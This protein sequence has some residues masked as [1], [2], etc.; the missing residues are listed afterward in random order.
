MWKLNY[1]LLNENLVRDEIKKEVK[2][3]LKLNENV[4]KSYPN[5]RKNESSAK[6]KVHSNVLVK[7]LIDPTLPA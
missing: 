5:L 6:R 1:S 3:F 2:D 4:D 7:N